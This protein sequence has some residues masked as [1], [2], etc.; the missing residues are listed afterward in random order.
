MK[1][2]FEVIRQLVAEAS[3]IDFANR[4]AG[5]IGLLTGIDSE[6]EFDGPALHILIALQEK[7]GKVVSTGYI[8]ASDEGDYFRINKMYANDAKTS[9]FL[10]AA[11]LQSWSRVFTDFRVS[12]AASDVIQRYYKQFSEDSSRIE[13]FA[14]NDLYKKKQ[15]DFLR[16]AYLGPVGFDLA[17]ARRAGD[18][19]IEKLSLESGADTEEIIQNFILNGS[20]EFNVV[21]SDKTK[22]KTT[23]DDLLKRKMF[24]QL[25]TS[26]IDEIEDPKVKGA[27]KAAIAWINDHSVEMKKILLT[28]AEVLQDDWKMIV[29][30]YLRHF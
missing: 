3:V 22:T 24:D 21:Y 12:P 11:A 8:G 2:L 13:K 1:I 17:S 28:C 27:Q 15:P 18:R 9:I 26:L 16:A 30:P 5:K 6:L 19:M 23:F 4:V 29:Q 10:L 14:D 25:I 7:D 20:N